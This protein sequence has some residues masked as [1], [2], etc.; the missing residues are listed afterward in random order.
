MAGGSTSEVLWEDATNIL[1][2]AAVFFPKSHS[3]LMLEAYYKEECKK[4]ETK[5][6]S[7]MR[8][9]SPLELL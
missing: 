8:I 7:C 2:A 4:T 5:L 1:W 9:Y 6:K 3:T